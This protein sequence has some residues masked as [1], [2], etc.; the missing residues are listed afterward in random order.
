M[1]VSVKQAVNSPAQFREQCPK[2]ALG[3]FMG[4]GDGKIE[5]G[6]EQRAG[7]GVPAG[8]EVKFP[9]ENPG[10]HPVCF[11]GDA[12]SIMGPGFFGA[13]LGGE[14]LGE[15]ETKEFVV[16]RALDERCKM[17]AARGHAQ[18]SSTIT[19]T[20]VALSGP[21]RWTAINTISLASAAGSS[22]V[23]SMRANSWSVIMRVTPSVQK[24]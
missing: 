4:L 13:A 8:G 9:Q 22:G 23:C 17:R 20:A 3:V 16:G 18:G 24:R 14:S 12:K 10:H 5:G 19:T 7:F 2:L 1:G 15:A 21:P 6:D 11:F